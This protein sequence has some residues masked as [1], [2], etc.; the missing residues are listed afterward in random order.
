MVFIDFVVLV[1]STSLCI[2][3]N[4]PLMLKEWKTYKEQATEKSLRAFSIKPPTQQK[5]R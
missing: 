2:Y 1:I 5:A 4:A 3:R